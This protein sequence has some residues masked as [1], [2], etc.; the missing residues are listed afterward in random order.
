MRPRCLILCFDGTGS[1]LIICCPFFASGL[2]WT[3]HTR[4]RLYIADK[5]DGDNTNIVKLFS[6]LKKDDRNEQMVYYQVIHLAYTRQLCPFSDGTVNSLGWVLMSALV[7]G[8]T[9]IVSIT[10][11]QLTGYYSGVMSAVAKGVDMAVAW[12]VHVEII[13]GFVLICTLIGTWKH[14]FSMDTSI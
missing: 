11:I 14:T 5:F 2:I 7:Y 9:S 3:P 1:S 4:R 8:G 12:Q 10:R 13:L 6:L